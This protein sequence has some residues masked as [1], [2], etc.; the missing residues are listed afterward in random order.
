MSFSFSRRAANLPATDAESSFNSENNCRANSFSRCDSL[1]RSRKFSAKNPSV[2]A[3]KSM[4]NSRKY[5]PHFFLFVTWCGCLCTSIFLVACCWLVACFAHERLQ[6]NVG[7]DKYK[8]LFL[9]KS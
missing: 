9:F 5:S 4:R 2:T 8:N 6:E 1:I 7:E 3:R